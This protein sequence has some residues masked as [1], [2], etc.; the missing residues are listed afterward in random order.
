MS[1]RTF[2]A[3]SLGA[4]RRLP[5]GPG[6]SS[7]SSTEVSPPPKNEVIASWGRLNPPMSLMI[8]FGAF[9]PIQGPLT[10]L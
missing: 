1:F 5:S 2:F 8:A 7:G 10:K 9:Q 4:I 6:V 3:H